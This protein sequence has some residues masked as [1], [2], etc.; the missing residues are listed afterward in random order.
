MAVRYS[1]AHEAGDAAGV[2]LHPHLAKSGITNQFGVPISD[3]T[4]NTACKKIPKDKTLAR[5][6][7]YIFSLTFYKLMFSLK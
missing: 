2:L 6:Q 1:L 5:F 7:L 3:E 4:Y